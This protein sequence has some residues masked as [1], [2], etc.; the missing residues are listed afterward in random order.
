MREAGFTEQRLPPT[1]CSGKITGQCQ[2][3]PTWPLPTQLNHHFHEKI[4]SKKK[5]KSLDTDCIF[6]ANHSLAFFN[7]IFNENKERV[8]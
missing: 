8:K 2:L 7:C 3:D 6:P 1:L 5:K 4:L